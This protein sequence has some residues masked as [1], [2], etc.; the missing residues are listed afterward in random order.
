MTLR[1]RLPHAFHLVQNDNFHCQMLY[2]IYF[3]KRQIWLIWQWKSQ[4]ANLVAN[5][6]WLI[7]TVLQAPAC[8]IRSTKV[9]FLA[10]VNS[11]SRSLY[12]IARPSVVCLSSVVYLSSVCNVGA[13]YSGGSDFRQYFYGIRYLG[14]WPSA[15]IHWKFYGDRP[16]RTPPPGELKTRGV[17]KY[18]DFGHIDGYFSE[19]V[20]DR[21]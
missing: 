13:P 21:R 5:R 20:Q 9:W 11:C 6:D 1:T 10:N 7:V 2:K 19:T 8:K 15:D 16:R 17:A 14:L 18:S 4:L 12:A 3:E